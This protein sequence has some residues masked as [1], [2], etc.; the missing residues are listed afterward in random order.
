MTKSFGERTL[1]RMKSNGQPRDHGRDGM[2]KKERGNG[3]RGPD[4]GGHRGA[5]DRRGF[6]H[7][8]P[9]TGRSGAEYA[10]LAV[11]HEL[12]R[13]LT[14]GDLEGQKIA[15]TKILERVKPLH[16][17][18]IEEL[19]FDCRTRLFT[20]LLRAGR[21]PAAADEAKETA[22]K[23]LMFLL[24]DIWRALGD[25]SRG[26]KL[27]AESG[28]TA[29]A[30]QLLQA[31]GEWQQAAA[32]H[33][34][35]G[36]PLDAARILEQHEDWSG[37]FA[38]FREA[39]DLRG[40][41]RTAL[42]AKDLDEARKAAK[43]LP[44]KA[45]RELLFKAKFGDLFLELLAEK[46]DWNEI[47]L[48]YERSEQWA[49]AGQ[50]FEKVGKLARAA[51]AWSKAG[52]LAAAAR[53]LDSAVKDRLGH[54]DAVGA[55][56]VLR[57]AGQVE[58]AAQLVVEAR[59]EMGFQWL[60]KAGLDAKALEFARARAQERSA[61]PAL[62]A[63]WLERAGEMPLAAQAFL[64]GNRPADAARLWESLGD[65]ERAGEAAARAG[66]T[67]RA[68][69]LLRRGGVG[70]PEERVQRLAPSAPAPAPEG[71]A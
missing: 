14:T 42:K 65:W 62:A 16:L 66:Q 11:L 58:R 50:A 67:D 48:L 1:G 71:P 60:Q 54:G 22:R 19:D 41:L 12:E 24:G 18:S 56:E 8:R 38:A 31:S 10:A 28:R 5:R 69:D 4:R 30:L 43:M 36:R 39:N 35:E 21:Q 59:P 13:P 68:V 26:A 45:A 3:P 37:A 46:G 9:A 63:V 15:F 40:W 57:R 23:D 20:A 33:R 52:D 55:G 7:D 47:A 29:P 17:K 44:L 70:D 61:T 2:E 64:D 6:G 49:D 27:Y 53:C 32:L 34:R 51:E 25:E